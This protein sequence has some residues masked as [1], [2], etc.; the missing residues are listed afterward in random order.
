MTVSNNAKFVS[1]S[2]LALALSS[3]IGSAQAAYSYSPFKFNVARTSAPN[4][5][6]GDQG[7]EFKRDVWM[8]GL[9]ATMPLNRQWSIGANLGY[10]NL[11]YGW[12][13]NQGNQLVSNEVPWNSINRY[14]VGLS[15]NYR[16]NEQ[17]MLML[18]PKLQYAYANTASSSNAE[19][20]GVVGMG[21]YRFESGN[22]LGMGVAYLNDISKVRTIPYL[23]V[24]WQINDNWVLTNPFQAGFSGPAG[25]ELRYKLNDDWD[26]GFGSSR[27]TER[28][29]VE[30]DDVSIEIEEWVSFLRAG[31]QA[32]KSVHVNMYGG[33]YFSGEMEQSQTE[34]SQEIENQFAGA[35][36]FEVKF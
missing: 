30:D 9:A 6:V 36:S 20:Y 14:S 19:S 13:I 18:A 35:V 11:D 25:L 17:W 5:Q 23:A 33:Y 32:S 22:M 24:K 15:V 4:A 29:L 3:S 21:M 12:K 16:P 28:F 2:I 8:I 26:F 7:N 31:W 34:F 10:D 1:G 27:R